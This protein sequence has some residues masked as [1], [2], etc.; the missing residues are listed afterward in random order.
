MKAFAETGCQVLPSG[1]AFA[2]PP[3]PMGTPFLQKF[4]T[5]TDN[6]YVAKYDLLADKGRFNFTKDPADEY[7]WRVPQLRNLPYTAP[8]LH[9][10]S[11]KTI[12]DDGP[13]DGQ[14]AVGAGPAGRRG[15]RHIRVPGQPDRRVP[16]GD[17]AAVAADAG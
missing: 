8:Y 14:G 6:P 16:E 9:N 1:A 7:M 12:P 13:P 5:S 3:L 15:G 11:V 2:G 10:G 17:H 4:P